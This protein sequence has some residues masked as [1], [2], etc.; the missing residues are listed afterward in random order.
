M[1]GFSNVSFLRFRELMVGANQ[2]RM[3]HEIH[4]RA[5]FVNHISSKRRTLRYFY[6][7]VK[8]ILFSQVRVVPR[9]VRPCIGCMGFF[10]CK[11]GGI[12][13]IYVHTGGI[14]RYYC[15]AHHFINIK[16][17]IHRRNKQWRQNENLLF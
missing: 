13:M 5:S 12:E 11:K 7:E 4:P 6:E 3:I 2:Y 9:H 10:I 14:A 1:T 8:T 15:F 17:F 16:T